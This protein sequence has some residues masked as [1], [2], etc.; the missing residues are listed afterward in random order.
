MSFNDKMSGDGSI[1]KFKAHLVAKGFS[2]IESIDYEEAFS[3]V[4]RIKLFTNF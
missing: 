3:L 2:Q 4:V 1:D